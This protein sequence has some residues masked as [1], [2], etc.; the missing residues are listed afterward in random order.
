LTLKAD[1]IFGKTIEEVEAKIGKG[2]PDAEEKEG[3]IIKNFAFRSGTVRTLEVMGK[4]PRPFDN[5]QYGKKVKIISVTFRFARGTTFNQAAAA[6]GLKG[7]LTREE[8]G[9][10]YSPS[11][12]EVA[13]V[14]SVSGVAGLLADT[15]ISWTP[16]P[17]GPELSIVDK[18]LIP[19]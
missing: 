4:D 19:F 17:A 1:A 3:T 14:D 7:S 13:K 10:R 6:A 15:V 11:G 5:L 8:D 16:L 9:T 18:S 12:E 2:K